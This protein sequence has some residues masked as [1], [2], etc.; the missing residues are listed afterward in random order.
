MPIAVQLTSN[1]YEDLGAAALCRN[2]FDDAVAEFSQSILTSRPDP[3]APPAEG[4]VRNALRSALEGRAESNARLGRLDAARADW[5]YL[6]SIRKPDEPVIAALGPILIRAWTGDAAGFLADAEA[7]VAFGAMK[8]KDL[9]RLA[10]AGCVALPYVTSNPALT[11]RLR[12]TAV[13]WLRSALSDDELS[14]ERDP[15]V[16]L[17]PRF[18]VIA[19]HPQIRLLKDDLRFPTEPFAS[20]TTR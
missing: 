16:L 17:D 14:S 10:K 3:K 11:E 12:A 5:S 2:R 18:D 9:V 7:L 19:E 15:Q 20:E 13:A 1:T 8:K 4:Q 6:A